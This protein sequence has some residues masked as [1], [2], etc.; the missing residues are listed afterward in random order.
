MGSPV[1]GVDKEDNDT[2][3]E[4]AHMMNRMRA[5]GSVF[6][7]VGTK[8]GEHN[9]ITM[10]KQWMID[11]AQVR[12]VADAYRVMNKMRPLHDKYPQHVRPDSFSVK[13]ELNV[14][15]KQAMLLGRKRRSESFDRGDEDNPAEM[16]LTRNPR[17]LP[18]PLYR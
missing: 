3:I 10:A 17:R 7:A 5:R 9:R 18:L 8:D 14:W 4:G 15:S 1:A 2:K 12:A 6:S 13:V 11:P 16:P